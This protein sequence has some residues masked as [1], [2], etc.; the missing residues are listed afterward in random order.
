MLANKPTADTTQRRRGRVKHRGDYRL[1]GKWAA[2]GWGCESCRRPYN[3]CRVEQ[4]H[5]RW[6]TRRYRKRSLPYQ[7]PG[8]TTI[9]AGRDE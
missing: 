4:L 1:P 3:A 7:V 2:C 9:T 6:L 5:E 8:S